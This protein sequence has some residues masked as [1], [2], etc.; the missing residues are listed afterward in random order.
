MSSI[1]RRLL[2]IHE[3]ICPVFYVINGTKL[4]SLFNFKYTN[5]TEYKYLTVIKHEQFHFATSTSL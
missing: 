2:D 1:L 4:F 3:L 5:T